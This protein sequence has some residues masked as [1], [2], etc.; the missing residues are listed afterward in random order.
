MWTTGTWEGIQ[1]EEGNSLSPRRPFTWF[2]SLHFWA[3][4]RLSPSS[5]F[6]C[7]W[8]AVAARFLV[9]ILSWC[10]ILGVACRKA[11][12]CDSWTFQ[13]REV[14][15]FTLML[16]H[17][18]KDYMFFHQN[19]AIKW[20]SDYLVPHISEFSF[21]YYVSHKNQ[22]KWHFPFPGATIGI[23]LFVFS[24]SNLFMNV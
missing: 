17:L 1:R 7:I 18:T 5:Y 9:G 16:Q 8:K 3:G 21:L 6:C 14:L 15:A 12:L 4:Q 11:S 23:Y 19:M 10:L 13:S 22:L 2:I 24:V 20:N